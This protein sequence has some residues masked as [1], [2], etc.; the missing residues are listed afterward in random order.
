[1]ATKS[2]TTKL[3]KAVP[4][5]DAT[6]S[7]SD[8]PRLSGEM[9]TE[10]KGA[11]DAQTPLRKG[12]TEK[13]NMLISKL[14]DSISAQFKSRVTDSRLATIVIE[15]AARV[16]AQVPTGTVQ[17]LTKKDK[18]KSALMTLTL[19]K[20]IQPGDNQ[21]FDHLTKM[22][23]VDMY[24]QVYGV[25]AVLY[26]ITVTEDYIGPGSALLP[27]R[28]W[29]PQPG[30]LSVDD[31]DYNYV[32]TWVS[33]GWLEKQKGKGSFNDGVIDYVIDQVAAEGGESK[34]QRPQQEKTETEIARDWAANDGGQGEAGQI[35]LITRYGGGEAGRWITFAPKYENMILRDCANKD[36]HIPIVLKHHIPLSDSIYGLGAFERGKTLQYAMDSLNAMY[37]A[38]VA[39]SIFPP[40]IVTPEGV[41][42][43]SLTYG[44]GETWE[45]TTPNSIR[46]FEV[47]PKGLETFQAS[48]SWLTG[49][50][51]NQNGTTDT[52]STAAGTN[53]PTAGKTPQALA[54]QKTREGAADNWDRFMM[55]QFLQK[56]YERMINLAPLTPKPFTFHI[57]D[58]EIDQLKEAKLDD[59]AEV[60]DSGKA[61]KITAGAAQFGK[62]VKYRFIIDTKSTKENDDAAEH[63][64]LNEIITTL[65]ENPQ[66]N[67]YLNQDGKQLKYGV[68]ME[69][70]A[71]TGGLTNADEIIVD[72][73][74]PKAP[75]KPKMMAKDAAGN[76]V[77]LKHPDAQPGTE[78]MAAPQATSGPAAPVAGSGGTNPLYYPTKKMYES[79]DLKD[80]PLWAQVQLLPMAGI[81]IP[82]AVMAQAQA[83]AAQPPPAA[84]GAGAPAP[85]AAPEA[86]DAT[87][88]PNHE[89]IIKWFDQ[90]S[91]PAQRKIA[92]AI[93]GPEAMQ[94]I[95]PA[96]AEMIQNLS[97]KGLS[98]S[99]AAGKDELPAIDPK[100]PYGAAADPHAHLAATKDPMVAALYK[101][102]MS[103][104]K[105][106]VP[107]EATPVEPPMA[108]TPA[109]SPSAPAPTG[110]Q[111]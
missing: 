49:S 43:D 73:P 11:Y 1:M 105:P 96:E 38:G 41:V 108:G 84:Q 75:P 58:A 110:G 5:E 94:G 71:Q 60:F 91:I 64:A 93:V 56:L 109:A 45:E 19:T 4:V 101:H 51:L 47:S 31:S 111:Q 82:P 59:V 100:S 10:W 3:Q 53:D 44:P 85:E 79:M 86:P 27:I 46:N 69:R 15:R 6:T 74:K 107:V 98:D 48:Y 99:D 2:A 97:S 8:L 76:V 89:F 63:A 95:M 28:S 88:D 92:M 29:Y 30:K 65:A 26:D 67:Y 17:A 33:A 61:A 106:G 37:L 52:T 54:L 50:L 80:L 34:Q 20:Y 72:I 103:S 23:L 16:M 90:L 68:L 83:Q 24:S 57:F 70:W 35:R 66:L 13:E 7:T 36:G 25:Q 62:N 39:M 102:I 18:G 22:R 87:K 21:Q 55:E 9:G 77:H 32:E 12:W 42:I 104:A 14:G 78:H 40:R 81:Q